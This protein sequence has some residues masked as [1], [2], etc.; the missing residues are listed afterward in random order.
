MINAIDRV[1]C[2][3]KRIRSDGTG[4]EKVHIEKYVFKPDPLR[5]FVFTLDAASLDRHE[6]DIAFPRLLAEL[7]LSPENQKLLLD[8]PIE[9]KCLMLTEQSTIRVSYI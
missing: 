5:R 9:K 4:D 2:C 3:L 6:V 1:L 8:Q 7:D